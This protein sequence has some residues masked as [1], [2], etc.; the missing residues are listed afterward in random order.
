MEEFFRELEKILESAT[1]ERREAI[2]SAIRTVVASAMALWPMFSGLGDEMLDGHPESGRP[3]DGDRPKRDSD[4]RIQELMTELLKNRF[5]YRILKKAF[6]PALAA[7]TW[8]RRRT[9]IEERRLAFPKMLAC[10]SID[11]YAVL[12]DEHDA[13]ELEKVLVAL[14]PWAQRIEPPPSTGGRPPIDAAAPIALMD[15]AGWPNAEIA[16]VLGIGV[17]TV[18]KLR[19]QT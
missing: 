19:N 11:P 9:Q 8:L 6:V 7:G 14:R 5:A 13:Q 10:E 1:E 2:T 16:K 12:S 17:R 15:E 4:P 3:G 18:Q